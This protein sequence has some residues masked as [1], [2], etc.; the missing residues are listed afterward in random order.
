LKELIEPT[1]NYFILWS[2]SQLF[3]YMKKTIKDFI[4]CKGSNKYGSIRCHARKV[5]S[6]RQ[7][8]CKKCEYDKHVETCH[9]KPICLFDE[10]TPI[11]IVNADSNLLLLCPNCHWEHDDILSSKIRKLET[12]CKC[13]NVKY[14]YSKICDLCE[15]ERRK[16]ETPRK[17]INRPS[18]EE[19]DVMASTMPMT[20]IGKKYG[21]S[22]NCIRK[23]IK[24]YV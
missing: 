15:R 12:T 23:W 10:S 4:T 18:K 21:V 8:K 5:T 6:T 24:S 3:I 20:S 17:V 2:S 1:T 7:Q 13:G 9:I 19:L 22:D 16:K 14:R 11:E